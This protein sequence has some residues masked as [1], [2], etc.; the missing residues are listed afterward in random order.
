MRNVIL[1]HGVGDSPDSFWLPY[2]RAALQKRGYD[3]WSP[4]L[5]DHMNPNL[6][7]QLPFVLQNGVFTSETIIIAHSAGCPLTLAVLENIPV[8]IKQTI[9][10]AGFFKPIGQ[11][12]FVKAITKEYYDWKKIKNNV[13]QF[14]AINSD[15]DPWGC[16]DEQGKVMASQA[17]GTLIVPH[18]EGHMG[19]NTH[20]QPYTDFP[21]LL[22]LIE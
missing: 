2:I 12:E 22:K 4:Q 20:N 13:E 14:I 3:V 8:R 11:L 18:G 5:P 1:L 15:N 19:S 7:V 10:V 6:V 9:L 17:G 16:T 21:L